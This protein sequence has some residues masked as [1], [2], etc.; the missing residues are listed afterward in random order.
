MLAVGHPATVQWTLGSHGQQPFGLDLVLINRNI[1][2]RARSFQPNATSSR[3]LDAISRLPNQAL[4]VKILAQLSDKACF[5]INVKMEGIR[6]QTRFVT[7]IMGHTAGKTPTRGQHPLKLSQEANGILDMLEGFEA[8]HVINR[9]IRDAS[10][11]IR[12]HSPTER[13][14]LSAKIELGVV[15]A[16]FTRIDANETTGSRFAAHHISTIAEPT[17]GIQH[18]VTRA[19][20]SGGKMVT[21]DVRIGA[22]ARFAQH[23]HVKIT[24]FPQ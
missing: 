5:V 21:S 8:K 12:Q 10:K 6:I 22:A 2:Q 24:L 4:K 15:D 14:V 13:C 17:R 23:V 16:I 18:R 20:E 11:A 9:I 3:F 19:D 7:P 1:D